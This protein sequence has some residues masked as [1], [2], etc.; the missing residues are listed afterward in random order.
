MARSKRIQ[1]PGL[2]RHVI[3]RGNGRMRIYLDDGDYRKFTFILSDVTDE[4]EIECLAYC[5]MPNHYHA[6]LRPTRANLSEAMR[7]L[8]SRYAQW[9]NREH[10]RVG[11]VFQGRFRDQI[12]QREGYLIA[13]CRYIALNPVRAGLAAH[14]SEWTWSSYAAT[15]GARPAPVFLAADDVLRQFGDDDVATLRTRFA[16]YVVQ[17]EDESEGMDARF[18]SRERILGSKDFK[19]LVKRGG[20]PED[21]SAYHRAAEVHDDSMVGIV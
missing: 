3:S 2:I 9:W 10:E 17:G 16:D 8:N 18:R 6:V 20:A 19:A 21:S 15:I 5:S 7:H 11:H 13:L 1:I 14:P 12:V 4:F